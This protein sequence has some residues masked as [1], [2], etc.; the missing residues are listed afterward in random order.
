MNSYTV[1]LIKQNN[2]NN[3]ICDVA[4]GFCNDEKKKGGFLISDRAVSLEVEIL[5]VKSSLAQSLRSVP[6]MIVQ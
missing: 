5:V 3:S 1:K 6:K 4:I 2:N